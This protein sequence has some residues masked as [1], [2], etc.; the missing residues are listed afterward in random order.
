MFALKPHI[1]VV[2][3][4][5]RLRDL[6][7]QFLQDQGFYVSVAANTA[8]ARR[9]LGALHTDLMVLDLMLPGETG[10]EFMESVR[11]GNVVPVLML[12]AMGETE[13]RIAGLERGVDDYLAKPFEPRELLLRIR[14]VLSR[15]EKQHESTRKCLFGEFIFHTDTRQ[16]L[17]GDEAV[18]LTTSEAELMAVL[19]EH[20]GTALSRERLSE[21]LQMGDNERTVDVQITRLRRKVEANPK[22]PRYIQ[23]VRGEGYVF[24][25]GK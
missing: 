21:T 3:D 13:D 16:L 14:A 5:D 15:Y 11:N 23:T 25:S 22:Q 24:R 19:A 20:E 1:L 7:K 12:S 4:D 6:L 2:D 8:D 17:H 10:L 18:Y 9:L